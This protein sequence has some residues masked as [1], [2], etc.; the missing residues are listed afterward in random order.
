[1]QLLKRGRRL[2]TFA[3]PQNTMQ[4]GTVNHMYFKHL[5]PT[6]KLTY[7]L[8]ID[9]WKTKFPFNPFQGRRFFCGGAG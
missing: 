8:K 2:L 7:P 3:G 6:E 1:M 5:Y 9:G 4:I